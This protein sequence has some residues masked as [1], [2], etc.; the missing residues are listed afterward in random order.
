MNSLDNIKEPILYS[1]TVDEIL[2]SKKIQ[3]F[4]K[5]TFDI[6]ASTIGLLILG[7][8]L[9]IIALIIK[10]T[11]EGPVFYRQTRVG[12]NNRDFKIFKFR[13]MIVDADKKG[14]LIT[15]GED[16]RITKIGKFLRKTKLDE[17]PQLINVFIGNMSFVGPRPEVRK[18][19]ELYDDFQRNVLKIKPGITDLASIKYRD[20][21]TLLGKSE[22]PEK[23]YIEEIMPIKL[24]INLE[25]ITK[26][27][28]LYDIKLIF[29]TL[30]RII[31]KG[32]NE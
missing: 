13:T 5:R 21:S 2:E 24:N 18:Y 16:K 10:I 20:E 25:Y 31:G 6:V 1:K 26:I 12:K 23:T 29:L 17:L 22:N 19:V 30:F 8:P 11:S 9:A 4:L 27:S 32:E 3:F 14:M 7:I 15:V 28:L